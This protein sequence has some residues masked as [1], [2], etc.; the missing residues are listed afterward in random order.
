MYIFIH[1]SIDGYL[2]YFQ[3][4]GIMSKAAMTILVCGHL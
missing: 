3:F 2:D 4:E 1:S